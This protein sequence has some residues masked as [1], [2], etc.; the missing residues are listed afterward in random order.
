MKCA[1]KAAY[2]AEC[3]CTLSPG[4]LHF[5]LFAT[6]RAFAAQTVRP[7]LLGNNVQVA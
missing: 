5:D 3:L 2:V 7:E 1:N 4:S 6:H